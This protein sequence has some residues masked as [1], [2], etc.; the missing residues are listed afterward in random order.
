MNQRPRLYVQH[1]RMAAAP[2]TRSAVQFRP[3]RRNPGDDLAFRGL[4]WQRK[5]TCPAA[6]T[7]IFDMDARP[8]AFQGLI[9]AK[10]CSTRAR[11]LPGE[12]LCS[13]FQPGSSLRPG[14]LSCGRQQPSHLTAPCPVRDKGVVASNAGRF[15]SGSTL[16]R[17]AQ[18]PSEKPEV[19]TS[20]NL[21]TFL[22]SAQG[23]DVRGVLVLCAKAAMAVADA[24]QQTDEL[25]V[26]RVAGLIRER[27]GQA[28]VDAERVGRRRATRLPPQARN[29]AITTEHGRGLRCRVERTTGNAAVLSRGGQ[30]LRGSEG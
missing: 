29:D 27:R 23:R 19:S 30:G 2:R 28:Q 9:R 12:R 21:L 18:S 16:H 1:A 14:S 25:R 10:V 22:G 11:T 6:L 8:A 15:P 7:C 13:S 17:G 3:P 5:P 4:K 20:R 24:Q 26:D